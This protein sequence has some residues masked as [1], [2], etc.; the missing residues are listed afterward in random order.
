MRMG[1]SIF[2]IKFP[3]RNNVISAWSSERDAVR[4]V[5]WEHGVCFK[6]QRVLPD[7]TQ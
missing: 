7:V 2:T 5:A 6:R 3:L 4:T 1:R